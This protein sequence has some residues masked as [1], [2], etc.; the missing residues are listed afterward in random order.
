MQLR[1]GRMDT[2]NYS[3]VRNKTLQKISEPRY[4]CELLLGGKAQTKHSVRSAVRPLAELLRCFS[5]GHVWR[6][7]AVYDHLFKN[8]S[9]KKRIKK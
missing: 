3:W 1:R 5:E 8:R 7:C 2:H 6:D 4:L 9:K